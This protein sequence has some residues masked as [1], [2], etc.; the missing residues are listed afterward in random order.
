[1]L[2]LTP[3][4]P[5]AGEKTPLPSHESAVTA[6]IKRIILSSG[7]DVATIAGQMNIHPNSLHQYIKGKRV[8]PSVMWLTRL[9]EVT[10]GKAYVEFPRPK[11][12]PSRV[13]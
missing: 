9:L 11:W 6:L 13:A 10:G 12:N 8:N 1:M 4:L 3:S 5:N 2:H 7:M